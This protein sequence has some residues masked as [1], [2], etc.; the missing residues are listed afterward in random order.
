MNRN[1]LKEELNR[2]LK[3]NGMVL[4][5][6]IG[7]V[8]TISH[9]L[10]YQLPA[11]YNNAMMDYE[12]FPMLYPF[13]VSDTWLAGNMST[14]ESFIYYLILPIVAVLPFGT[15]YFTDIQ[16]GFLKSMYMKTTRREYL[17]GKYITTF[18]SGGIA[19]TL[20]LVINLIGALIFLPNL[21]AQ[22]TM[23]YNGIGAAHFLNEIYYTYPLIYIFFFLCLDFVFGGIFASVAL[24]CSFL[25]DYK[26]VVM[27][28][29]FFLQLTIHVFVSFFDKVD[30][31]SVF[32]LNS[33]YGIKHLGVVFIYILLGICIPF[34]IF[35]CKGKKEDVF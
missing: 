35:L 16:S 23:P 18:L 4:A 6:I 7:C 3:G 21:S 28:C 5:L 25:S 2:A 30:Y 27:I 13:V 14:L 19:V 24:T 22:V 15:S 8:I 11:Y 12:R 20:P 34:F 17:M 29:P 26:I 9:M 1:V 33:G 31:S 32:F 10:K